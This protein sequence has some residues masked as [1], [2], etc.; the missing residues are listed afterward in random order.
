MVGRSWAQESSSAPSPLGDTGPEP[1]QFPCTPN[2]RDEDGFPR[3]TRV[4]GPGLCG[5]AGGGG[6]R[7]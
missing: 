3:V 2:L 1:P 6:T 4:L 5:R 7:G